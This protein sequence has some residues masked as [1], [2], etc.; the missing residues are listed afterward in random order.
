MTI[1]E[2]LD[3]IEHIT[4]GMA[5]QA[6]KDREENRQLSRDTQRQIDDLARR[7][8]E[9]AVSTTQLT[10]Q[11]MQLTTQSIE[12]TRQM[13]ELAIKQRDTNDTVARLSQRIDALVPAVGGWIRT[14]G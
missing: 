3:R 14:H 13:G 1:D 4:A 6:R 11:S 5:E 10:A 8:T 7:T 2:R 12:L 9:L